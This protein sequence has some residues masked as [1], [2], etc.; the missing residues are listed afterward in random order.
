MEHPM[1]CCGLYAITDSRL[2]PAGCVVEQVSQAI[3]GGA[4]LIQYREKTLPREE[5][6]RE[7]QAQTQVQRRPARWPAIPGG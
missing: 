6:I 4:V 7:A 2:I 3:D 1:P 5:R